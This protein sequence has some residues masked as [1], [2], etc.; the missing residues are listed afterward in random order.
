MNKWNFICLYVHP[1]IVVKFRKSCINNILLS[2]SLFVSLS[3]SA[4]LSVSLSLSLC[5][6]LSLS[7]SLYLSLSLSVSLCLCLSFSL[8]GACWNMI[9]ACSAITCYIYCA[10]NFNNWCKLKMLKIHSSIWRHLR[11]ICYWSFK[12]KLKLKRF[13]QLLA[14]LWM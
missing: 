13:W 14:M 9:N 4:S 1:L 12:N 3:L 10:G 7:L 2:S 5:L 8:S 11:S 6:C